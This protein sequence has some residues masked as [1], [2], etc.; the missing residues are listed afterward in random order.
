[1]EEFIAQVYI[2]S[3]FTKF[4]I[5]C[6]LEGK[7]DKNS[8]V[9]M[10]NFESRSSNESKIEMYTLDFISYAKEHNISRVN[11]NFR[12][13][14]GIQQFIDLNMLEENGIAVLKLKDKTPIPQNG[15]RVRKI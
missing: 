10:E 2:S 4:V 8:F 6:N 5:I 14:Y 7:L 11:I 9:K 13:R 1:M 3:S 15:C 12:G